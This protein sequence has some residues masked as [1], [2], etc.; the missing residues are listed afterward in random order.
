M[1][2][3]E[4]AISLQCFHFATHVT[5]ARHKCVVTWRHVIQRPVVDWRQIA[6]YVRTLTC[7]PRVQVIFLH[8]R[9][10]ARIEGPK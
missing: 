9:Q 10:D 2:C 4:D 3:P 1:Q 7:S 8:T 5:T 6:V